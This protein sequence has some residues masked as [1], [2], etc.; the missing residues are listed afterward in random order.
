MF[1][2]LQ[3]GIRSFSLTNIFNLTVDKLFRAILN[4]II[5]FFKYYYRNF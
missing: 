1:N 3:D 2:C 4:N 5:Y